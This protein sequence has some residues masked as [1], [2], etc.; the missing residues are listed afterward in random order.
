MKINKLEFKEDISNN[1]EL[2]MMF[3][4]DDYK[5][6]LQVD[7]SLQ[8]NKDFEYIIVESDNSIRDE[9]GKLNSFIFLFH[10]LNE[11]S[12]NKYLEWAERLSEQTGK[13]VLLFPLAF[14]IN[15]SPKEWADPRFMLK[16][17]KADKEVNEESDST[18]FANYA[19]SLRLKSQPHRFYTAGRQTIQNICQLISQIKSGNHA[20][21]SQSA[22]FDIFAYSIGALLSQVIIM[23]NPYKYFTHSKLFIFCGGVMFNKM[24]GVSK[25]IMD[26]GAFKA[27]NQY[28]RKVFIMFFKYNRYTDPL[29]RAFI[30]H[31][32]KGMFKR[33]RRQFYSDNRDRIKIICLKKDKVMPCRG[34][35]SALGRDFVDSITKLDFP[36]E[37]SHEMPFPSNI[38]NTALKSNAFSEVFNKASEFL[39][40]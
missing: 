11:R 24:N 12:W 6:N 38:Q 9:K 29:E 4:S 39:K 18:S 1:L 20:K 21:I 31:L 10:G 32:G 37:Y 34:L 7:E 25:L 3:D 22:T 16:I 27:L 15:R 14:H 28:Y 35:N 36:F 13:A 8:S 33:E 26:K 5:Y 2:S 30:A 23:A 17:L 40:K 19:L